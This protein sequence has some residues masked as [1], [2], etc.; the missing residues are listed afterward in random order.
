MPRPSTLPVWATNANYTGGPAVGTPSC[1]APSSAKQQEGWDPSDKPGAQ[2]Q[3]WWQNLVYQWVNWLA[4]GTLDGNWTFTGNVA[5]QGTLG[6]TGA[7]TG[8]ADVTGTVLHYTTAVQQ[9]LPALTSTDNPAG[10]PGTHHT[11]NA[12][13]WTFGANTNPIY[14]PITG[15]KVGDHI[16]SYHSD[17]QKNDTGT[18]ANIEIV[19]TTIAGPDAVEDGPISSGTGAGL[20]SFGNTCDIAVASGKQYYV[21]VIPGGTVT[22]SADTLQNV[23]VTI[24]H[25]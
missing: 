15:L 10:A 4:A 12:G 8:S 14:Y 13:G 11:R 20:I 1:V 5:I 7:I 25:P 18:A 24:T 3:N 2:N 17:L 16:K 23:Y 22:P 9:P 21:K 19:S 6:V